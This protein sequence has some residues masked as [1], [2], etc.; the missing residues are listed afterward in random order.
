[1]QV[2]GL[3]LIA[4]V[5]IEG[6]DDLNEGSHD[7]GEES[8]TTKHNEDAEDH[9]WVRSRAQVTVADRGQRRNREIARRDHLVVARGVLKGEVGNKVRGAILEQAGPEVEDAA[10]EV[11][12]DDREENEP[13]DAVNILHDEGEDHFLAARLVR[14]NTLNQLVHT[15]HLQQGEDALDTH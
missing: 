5:L 2:K 14:E 12:D 9:L 7:I 6:R 8:D 1:M 4:K 3:L 13:E 11:G 15:V 10:N